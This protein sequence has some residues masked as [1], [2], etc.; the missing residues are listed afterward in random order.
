MVECTTE[1]PDNDSFT[2]SAECDMGHYDVSHTYHSQLSLSLVG[3]FHIQTKN[4]YQL[5]DFAINA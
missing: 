4:K 2:E 5:C 3:L 1:I